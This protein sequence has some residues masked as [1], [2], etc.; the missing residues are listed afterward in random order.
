M[1]DTKTWLPLT[2]IAAVVVGGLAVAGAH[3]RDIPVIHGPDPEI[4]AM[5]AAVEVQA[6]APAKREWF[7]RDINKA[8]CI[9]SESP[10]D[11]M[12]D[13]QSWGEYARATDIAGGAVEVARDLR[14]GRTEVWTFFPNLAACQASLPRNQGIS[15]RYE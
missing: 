11:K 8:S 6:P 2:I 7:G 10:A 9:R 14:G 15:S 5:M 4:D 3:Q 13:I 12:R 1:I